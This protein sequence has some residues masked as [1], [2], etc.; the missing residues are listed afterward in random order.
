MDHLEKCVKQNKFTQK[1][2]TYVK[3]LESNLQRYPQSCSILSFKSKWPTR[4]GHSVRYG[5]IVIIIYVEK[6]DYIKNYRYLSLQ[7]PVMQIHNAS[8]T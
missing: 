4:E 5:T 8:V 6:K 1:T 7:L 2:D 3:F